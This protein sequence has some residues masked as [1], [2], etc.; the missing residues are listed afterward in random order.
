MPTTNNNNQTTYQFW[1]SGF[2]AASANTGL[3]ITFD[4]W[5]GL[6]PVGN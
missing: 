5:P 2:Y 1:H 4:M 6:D 3:N